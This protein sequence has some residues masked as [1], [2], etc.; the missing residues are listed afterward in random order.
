MISL[1]ETGLGLLN[2]IPVYER[3]KPILHA[4]PEVSESKV[5]PGVLQGRIEVAKLGFQYGEGAQI[6]KDVSF[7]AQPGEYI[8]LVGPSG[9]GK[10]TLLRLLL[11][12]EKATS[13]T[14]YYD[15]QDIVDLDLNALRR[16]FGVV[17][18]SG[19]LMPADIFNNIVG[20]ANLTLEDAWEAARMV[21]L[22]EDIKKMPMGMYTVISDGA[23]TFS[24]GQRQRIMI[25][26]AIVHRPRI[27]FF[28]EA[29]SA[30]DNHT[31]SIVTA[32]L[33]QMKTTRIVIAHR[34][35]TVIKADRIIVLQ[36]GRIV[37]DGNYKELI[38]VPGLFQDL[39]TRQIA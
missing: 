9:S 12:F 23:S 13:G 14:I 28:D 20:A 39:A 10:S 29:T 37:Q 5:H 11:G 6:L 22:D 34:L 3:A 25:A 21:G 26:R 38:A 15:K 19:Q 18:Q 17:L 35:S 27:L 4:L 36:D 31:Q 2:L 8:A 33:D 32:S 24:G 16:Q 7:T 1:I 30:L